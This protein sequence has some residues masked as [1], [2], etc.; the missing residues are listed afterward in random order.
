[1]KHHPY[2][3]RLLSLILL[4]VLLL[5]PSPGAEAGWQELL[6]SASKLGNTLIKTLG[7][8]EESD[9]IVSSPEDLLAKA[10][11]QIKLA[12]KIAKKCQEL[13]AEINLVFIRI[14]AY[15]AMQGAIWYNLGK[16]YRDLLLD[17]NR[18]EKEGGCSCREFCRHTRNKRLA[19]IDLLNQ[20]AIKP[21]LGLVETAEAIRL[22]NKTNTNLRLAVREV[23]S[24][25]PP[26]SKAFNQQIS[27]Q[28]RALNELLKSYT[29]RIGDIN[30][31]FLFAERAFK[32]I[33]KELGRAE[34]HMSTAIKKFN[35]QGQLVAV[36]ALK[37]AGILAL[38]IAKLSASLKEHSVFSH[39]QSIA[40]TYNAI[41][42]LTKLEKTLNQFASN[43]RRFSKQSNIIKQA[44]AQA[45]EEIAASGL[46][47]RSLR[48]KLNRSWKKQ[49]TRISKIAAR[50]RL[51]VINL[52]REMARIEKKNRKQT[53]R[54]YARLHQ[55]AKKKADK[56][57]GKPVF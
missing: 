50:E 29:V 46:T 19:Q 3:R 39:F 57:F 48:K 4:A 51:K 17:L 52:K 30:L 53:R 41:K 10:L 54:M 56:V 25:N 49:V 1:M 55:E 2:S 45:R 34:R 35:E 15:Q 11:D 9:V 6:N 18:L 5:V 28:N 14:R 47:I 13:E 24:H 16:S 37:H 20:V 33:A 43:Y 27:R 26:I 36:E 8:N 12:E 38:H 7:P 21:D 32:Q 40:Q 44:A 22:N 42:R 31:A 23:I